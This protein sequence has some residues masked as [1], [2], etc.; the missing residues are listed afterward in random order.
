MLLPPFEGVDA[1]GARLMKEI[2]LDQLR[3]GATRP[4]RNRFASQSVFARVP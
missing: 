2:L 1:V 4:A 3:R